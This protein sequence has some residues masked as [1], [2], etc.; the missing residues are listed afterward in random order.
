VKLDFDTLVTVPSAPPAAG[1]DRALDGALP[2]PPPLG[3]W[4]A[5]GVVF[6]AID[7]E[8]DVAK[9]TETPVAASASA[10]AEIHRFRRLESTRGV[11]RS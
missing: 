2:D 1:A 4:A 11:R 9:P 3:T 10:A 6:G 7:V 5:N 8:P